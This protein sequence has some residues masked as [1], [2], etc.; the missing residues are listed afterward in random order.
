MAG[1]GT[2]PTRKAGA[3]DEWLTPPELI[4]SLGEFDLDPCS[5]IDRPW[6]TAK[7]HYSIEDDGLSQPWAGR[8][9]MNPPYG[10]Q[11][12]KWLSRLGR[13]GNGIALVFAR[14]ETQMFAKHVW[15]R[16]DAVLFVEGRIRFRKPDG[17]EGSYTSGGPSAL[18]AYGP[19]NV[20]SL[21]RSGISGAIVEGWRRSTL[22]L[23]LFDRDVV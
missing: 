14:T 15:G 1:I 20:T 4:R 11:T 18:I 3:T 16:A 9:W 5:P 19:E 8:V 6:D 23:G 2:H 10:L 13:H 17:S 22:T 12:G 7:L 21:R